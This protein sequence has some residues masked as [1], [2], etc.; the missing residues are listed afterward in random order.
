MKINYNP[1]DP[2]RW[3]QGMTTSDAGGTNFS[4]D[5]ED[6]PL[7][8]S[9]WIRRRRQQLDLTQE[10]L[11]K[12][13]CCSVFA[14]R[15][16]EMGERRP[17]RQLAGLLSQALEIS[18]E[19]QATFVQIARGELGVER[20]PSTVHDAKFD[21][22]SG[23]TPG[24]L[25][26]PLTP[27]IGREPE[28]TALRQMLQDP[29]CS[30]ITIVGPGGIGKTRLAIEA[31]FQ[32]KELFPD[33]VWFAPLVSLISPDLIVPAIANAIE[34]K[35]QSPINPQAQLI[36]YLRSKKAL[37]V[38]D[39]VEHLLEGVGVFTEI[40]NDCQQVKMLVTSRERL[41]LLSEWVFE[42]QGLPLPP[43]DQVEQFEAY[44][45][46]ALFLQSARRVRAGFEMREAEQG[47]VLKIC[48]TME[49]MPL[50]IE[51]SAAWVGLLSC[52]EIAKEIEQ[53]LDFLSSSVRDLP[54]RHRSL[55]ATVD[56]SWKLLNTEEKGILSRL[57]VFHGKFRREA[58]E[59]ICRASLAVLASL[60]DKMLLY[61]TDEDFYHL[62]EFI[63]A[64]ARERLEASGEATA[65]Q[66]LHA[67]YFVELSEA[68]RAQIRGP[69]QRR[70]LER[71]EQDHDNIRAALA[72][73]THPSHHAVELG[74]RLCAALAYF[75]D[76]HGYASE[77]RRWLL[78]ALELPAPPSDEST[79]TN[80]EGEAYIALRIKV[81]V[82]SGGLATLQGDYEAARS[83]TRE[84]LLLCQQTGNKTYMATCLNNLGNT[85]VHLGNYTRALAFHEQALDL[86]RELEDKPGI[87]T[88]LVNMGFAAMSQGDYPSARAF[89]IECVS[90]R[91]EMG[92]KFGIALALGNLGE[93]A[94]AEQDYGSAQSLLDE[95]L[96]LRREL[97]DERGIAFCL[98]RFA[99]L[100]RARCNYT[101]ARSLYRE[102]LLLYRKVG[103]RRAMASTL[104]ERAE[105][106]ANMDQ[107]VPAVRLW[108]AA[109]MLC[110]S[111]GAPIPPSYRLRYER[112]LARARDEL[113]EETF[114]QVW[115]EGKAM[116]FDQTV[117]SL[118][119]DSDS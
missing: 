1:N 71:L 68:A 98:I 90:L 60:R 8:F 69:E 66:R 3:N 23:A 35:F 113:G 20:L 2:N 89:L 107:M 25:P 80:L 42:I 92:D 93:V 79:N 11:A 75:W 45:S 27:F 5:E 65:I 19:D 6:V 101:E 72:W 24:N 83:F 30:L 47:W 106:Y 43:S 78:A 46:V 14:I 114:Q 28:L 119:S 105:L 104:Q 39:N 64:Y 70:W 63:R 58:A 22:K 103:D 26:R 97:G 59:E 40:L 51:L 38:L 55:R 85:E 96:S 73:S 12:R 57:S 91:R 18:P 86:R 117:D 49:G 21:G 77:G 44:S 74:L 29:Q 118:L 87:A 56:H 53:N 15:K 52:E 32:S 116:N 110:Q 115:A 41:N 108:S 48:R 99:N 7:F 34:F 61:R 95:S 37:L 9:E 10:Q 109:E 33:G 16:I 13:A 94:I 88:S 111:L 82:A 36:R 81:L 17:S 4:I 76:M 84:A 112:A 100:E 54:E 50:G 67:K 31:A 102:G 62:H